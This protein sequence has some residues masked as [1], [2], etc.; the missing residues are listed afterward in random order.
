MVLPGQQVERS[1]GFPGCLVALLAECFHVTSLLPSNDKPRNTFF[2]RLK[3]KSWSIFPT[4]FLL[5][6]GTL[7]HVLIKDRLHIAC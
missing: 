4:C 1:Q 6:L 2:Y 5:I 7:R 3:I